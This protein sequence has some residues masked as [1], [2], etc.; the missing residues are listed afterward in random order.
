ML[1]RTAFLI[2][3]A[4]AFVILPVVFYIAW[5]F[6]IGALQKPSK[7]ESFL[8]TKAKHWTGRCQ[9]SA[10]PRKRSDFGVPWMLEILS[11]FRMRCPLLEGFRGVPRTSRREVPGRA[12][13]AGL[14]FK[15]GSKWPLGAMEAPHAESS[16]LRGRTDRGGTQ[17]LEGTIVTVE[18]Q[19]AR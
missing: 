16:K 2:A 5:N 9:G 17:F 1:K 14:A 8:A 18:F 6:A 19:R 15:R 12:L 3:M 7:A 11:Q 10:E 4:A 13:R